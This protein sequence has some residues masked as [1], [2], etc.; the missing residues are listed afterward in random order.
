MVE[1]LTFNQVVRSSSLRQ[2]T[3]H[4]EGKDSRESNKI[5]KTYGSIIIRRDFK[6]L[7]IISL[8]KLGA[9]RELVLN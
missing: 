6:Y 1:H 2:T 3:K 7:P 8:T 4:I 5:P 9:E